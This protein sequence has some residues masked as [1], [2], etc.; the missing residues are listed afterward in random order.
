M[1]QDCEFQ[2]SLDYKANLLPQSREKSKLTGLFDQG[3]YPKQE[4]EPLKHNGLLLVSPLNK[5]VRSHK[6]VG[7][8]QIEG[9][10]GRL[11]VCLRQYSEVL[12]VSRK[13]KQWK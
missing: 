3:T 7:V 4:T 12:L 1:R 8:T 11:L 2:A 5:R 6:N 13:V 10:G 9:I